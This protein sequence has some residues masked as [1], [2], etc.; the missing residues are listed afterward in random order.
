M[1]DAL[2]SVLIPYAQ[3]LACRERRLSIAAERPR[4]DE[5]QRIDAEVLPAAGANDERTRNAARVLETES[6]A[7]VETS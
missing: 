7:G 4:R 3:F 6:A 2:A 5:R 1:T